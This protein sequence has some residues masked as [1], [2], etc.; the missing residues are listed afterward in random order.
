[1]LLHVTANSYTISLLNRGYLAGPVGLAAHG[2]YCHLQAPLLGEG[3][4]DGNLLNIS[5]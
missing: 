4:V 3:K 5:A 1:M 2:I